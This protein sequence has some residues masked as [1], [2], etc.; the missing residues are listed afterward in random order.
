MD[1]VVHNRLHVG[2][3]NNWLLIGLIIGVLHFKGLANNSFLKGSLDVLH[4]KGFD[5]S[6]IA[7]PLIDTLKI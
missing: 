5:K 6:H 4:S 1:S 2:L 7:F 3:S